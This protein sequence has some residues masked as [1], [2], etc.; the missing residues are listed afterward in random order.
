M[1]YLDSFLSEVLRPLQTSEREDVVDM[2]LLENLRIT[3]NLSDDMVR[4]AR[5][6]PRI[7]TII[8]TVDAAPE[9]AKKSTLIK[10]LSKHDDFKKA[11][12]NYVE[13]L[14]MESLVKNLKE[15]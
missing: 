5:K 4:H 9:Q 11:L 13:M 14:E 1:D 3:L 8:Q 15:I 7:L 2:E 10:E 6:D 12:D